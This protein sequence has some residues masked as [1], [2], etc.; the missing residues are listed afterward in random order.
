[1]KINIMKI[2][3]TINANNG[4]ILTDEINVVTKMLA[5]SGHDVHYHTTRTRSMIPLP[6]A[7]FHD[8]AE[9]TDNSFTE[10]DALLVFNGNANFYGGQEA[11]GDLMA[12]K[13]IDG[14]ISILEMKLK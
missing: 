11:R 12:Y 1:M 2:G 6:H 9:V 10:Y 4:S 3:A 7:T 13:F 5:D 14:I 8:L